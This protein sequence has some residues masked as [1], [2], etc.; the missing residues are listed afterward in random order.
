[1][2]ANI[3]SVGTDTVVSVQLHTRSSNSRDAVQLCKLSSFQPCQSQSAITS[4][5]LSAQVAT[6]LLVGFPADF[7]NKELLDR[8]HDLWSD[9]LGGF[10]AL[11]INLPGFGKVPLSAP[12]YPTH[13]PPDPYLL[14]L[15]LHSVANWLASPSA[16]MNL[17]M[18]AAFHKAMLA[19]KALLA[20]YE[21][22]IRRLK[23]KSI[24]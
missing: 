15:L 21:L 14:V 18:P 16:Y 20:E 4:L 7:I 13:A 5:G 2:Y 17:Q 22:N 23:D 12:K 6:E 11:P 1:M 8:Q 19:R 24:R 3:E 9:W 10:L